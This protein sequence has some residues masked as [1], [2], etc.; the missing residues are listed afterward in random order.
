MDHTELNR[1]LS[2]ATASQAEGARAL[3]FSERTFREAV[4]EGRVP[5]I[6]LSEKPKAK[7][8][9]PTNWIAA[10]LHARGSGEAA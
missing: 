2:R 8:N 4:R 3:G 5:T 7:K 9:I 6:S 1:L 10:Q